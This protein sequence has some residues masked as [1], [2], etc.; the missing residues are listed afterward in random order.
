[1]THPSMQ[2]LAEAYLDLRRKLGCA[3]E[4]EGA[5]LLAFARFADHTGHRGFLTTGLAVRWAKRPHAANPI[6]WARRLD[7]VRRFAR[8]Q[9]ALEP[10]TEIPPPRLLGPSYRR[11]QPHVFSVD[12]IA[13]LLRA[14]A[15]LADAGGLRPRT[16]STLFGLLAS[17]GLRISEALRLTRDEVDLRRGMLRVSETKFYKSR[18]VPL[19]PTTTRALHDYAEHRDRHCPIAQAKTFFV[20]DS[21]LALKSS[22][23]RYIFAVLLR[24]LGWTNRP[25]RRLPRIHDLRHSFACRRLLAWYEEEAD[26]NQELP[27]LSTYL[28]HVKVTDTYWYITAVPDLMAVASAR[29]E[30]QVRPR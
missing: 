23:V 1:M 24:R 6:W 15:A 9:L 21:G 30:R 26:I 10:R 18:L 17:T 14:A 11:P 12:E 22:A 7:V 8:R 20:S 25:Q 3:L 4:R 28:G 27:A 13:A 29:F 16:Y 2:S 19:H 5:L